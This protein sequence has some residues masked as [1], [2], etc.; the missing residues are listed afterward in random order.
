MFWLEQCEQIGHRDN[1]MIVRRN[2]STSFYVEPNFGD[3]SVYS[4]YL[5][6]CLGEHKSTYDTKAHRISQT[7]DPL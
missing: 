1:Q 3:Q 7:K 5:R 2:V 6:I 4:I